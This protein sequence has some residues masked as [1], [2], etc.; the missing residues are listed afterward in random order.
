MVSSKVNHT[1]SVIIPAETVRASVPVL[2]YLKRVDYPQ[3]NIEIIM[4]IGNW[5]S[6]QRNQA[7]AMA[8]GDILYFF[9]RDTQVQ[10]DVFKRMVFIINKDSKIAGVGGVDITPGANSHIQHL[11]GYAMG[12]YFAHWK[13]RARYAQVGR[14]RA[15]CENELLLSNM[16]IKRG[17]F[18][19]AGGFNEELYP[20]EEN[21]L[22]NRVLKMGYKFIY[23]PD[24]KI[25]RDRRNS[26]FKFIRQ[27]HCYGQ[28]RL[29]QI[30]IEGVFKNFQFLIPLFF[31]IYFICLFFAGNSRLVFIPF[32]IYI[33]LA[34]FDS[35]CLTF[36]NKKNLM[37][38]PVLYLI[39][40]FSY[41]CGFLSG[42]YKN[43]IKKKPSVIP[44]INYKIIYIK[45]IK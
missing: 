29:N 20:N 40:H 18:L 19:E 30:N 39:M 34:M 45:E 17:I 7:A 33:A 31:F 44:K 16:A 21:E 1:I 37:I 11:F 32:I 24:I 3:E 4:S 5:P 41:A 28:G 8:K 13:M 9:N 23:S 2:D 6:A 22:I 12:S 36:K 35:I 26:I 43:I 25:Y 10:P 14:E 42:I 38:L 15:A 27:F